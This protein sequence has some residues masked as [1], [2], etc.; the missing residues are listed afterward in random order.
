MDK[1]IQDKLFETVTTEH[2]GIFFKVAKT[3]CANDEDQKDLLQEMM[4]QVWNALPRYN[5]S[6][7]LNT[8]LYR[9][10]LNVAISQYRRSASKHR[11]EDGVDL[12]TLSMVD[13][14]PYRGDELELLDQFIGE[15]NDIDKAL[16]ILYL[17]EKSQQEIAEIVGIT[18]TNVSTK[19]ARI[20][21]KLKLKFNQN[22]GR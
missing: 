16:I 18:T 9:V 14:E 17:E 15:L 4:V 2:K 22:N 1:S 11:I 5:S 6:Y 13:D 21:E 20:K 12:N 3:Y 10:V 7:K 19:I 8:W